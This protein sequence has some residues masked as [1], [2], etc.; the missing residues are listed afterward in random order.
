LGTTIA[1]KIV[2]SGFGPARS[3]VESSS[4]I[5]LGFGPP[6][7][8]VVQQIVETV[9]RPIR[10]RFGQSGT[11]RRLEDLDEVIV[12]AQLIE[13]NNK[14]PANEIKGFIKVP[15]K[16]TQGRSRIMVEHVSSRVREAWET[17]K[18]TVSRMK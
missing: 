16:K 2:T 18:V 9:D 12:W 10:L 14:P 15:V 17:I 3:T 7:S 13:V 8:F 11:K 6:P 4:L 1:N 5:T